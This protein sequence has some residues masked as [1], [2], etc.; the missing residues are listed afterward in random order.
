M[1]EDWPPPDIVVAN[2]V[3]RLVSM[4]LSAAVV[5]DT[6]LLK[7]ALPVC[8]Y[9]PSLRSTT[10]QAISSIGSGEPLIPRSTVSVVVLVS[11]ARSRRAPTSAPLPDVRNDTSGNDSLRLTDCG[12]V[13]ATEV[14]APASDVMPRCT[15]MSTLDVNSTTCHA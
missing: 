8:T 5:L 15:E 7:W 10:C 1:P 11:C 6:P 14:A 3:D 4:L 12:S 13:T 9:E 2:A